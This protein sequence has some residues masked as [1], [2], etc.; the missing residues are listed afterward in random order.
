MK[1]TRAGCRGVVTTRTE[2]WASV[3]L[4]SVSG[5]R[6]T[7]ERS[8]PSP[9]RRRHF[10]HPSDR[11]S[12]PIPP[13]PWTSPRA[14]VEAVDLRHRRGVLVDPLPSRAPPRRPHPPRPLHPRR[15]RVAM[16]QLA[17]HVHRAGRGVRRHLPALQPPTHRAR[18]RDDAARHAPPHRV[19]RIPRAPD[20]AVQLRRPARPMARAD[21]I[22]RLAP[23]H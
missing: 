15:V 23:L 8:R 5:P 7:L 21:G 3:P 20:D 12:R 14:R 22:R 13:Q 19:D 18:A 9:S 6:R 10:F 17:V 2:R 1:D 11:R 4:V 16:A